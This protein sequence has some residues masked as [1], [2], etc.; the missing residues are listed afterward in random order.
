MKK[1]KLFISS[2]LAA[3]MSI[4]A[5]GINVFAVENTAAPALAANAGQIYSTE[6][7]LHQ[8]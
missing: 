2:G 7:N 6:S 8:C 3:V 5:I 1:S 4:S